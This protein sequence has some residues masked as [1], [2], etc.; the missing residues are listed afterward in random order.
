MQEKKQ[1]PGSE[2]SDQQSVQP[3]KIVRGFKEVEGAY[4]LCSGNKGTD[5]LLG[6]R[7]AI[8]AFVFA[9]SK[10]RFSNELYRKKLFLLLDTN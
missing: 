9:Y 4:Y 7:T 1:K 8:C 5:Q 6:Y 3:Q 2:V 10:S